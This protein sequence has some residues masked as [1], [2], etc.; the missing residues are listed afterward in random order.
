MSGHSKWSKVKHQKA[1]TDVVKA[2]EF[3]KASR[4]ITIAVKEGGGVT[5]PDDNFRLRLAIEKAKEVNMPKVN[6]DRAIEKGSGTGSVAIE[7]IMYEGFAPGGVALCIDA[8]TDNKQRTVAEVKNVLERAGGSLGG[9]GA[10]SYL[11]ARCGLLAVQK[12][13]QSVDTMYTIAIDTGADDVQEKDTVFELYTTM[14]LL[15]STKKK[16]EE[17]GIMVEGVALVMKPKIFVGGDESTLARVEQLAQD[18]EDLED[19]QAV[20]TNAGSVQ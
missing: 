6:I 18:L 11:F 8:T 7:R 15:F 13:S 4:G 17:R 9:P 19:V 1:T 14:E 16:L 2:R 3:T 12:G 5:N 10:V 20:Y